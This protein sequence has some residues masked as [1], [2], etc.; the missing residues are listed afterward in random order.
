MSTPTEVSQRIKRTSRLL[1]V[2]HYAN[3]IHEIAIHIPSGSV[4][5]FSSTSPGFTKRDYPD[6]DPAIKD[7]EVGV[8][9]LSEA[10]RMLRAAE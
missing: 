6:I 10:I 2:K 4:E 9:L 1:A 8:A 7:I 5:L 3:V